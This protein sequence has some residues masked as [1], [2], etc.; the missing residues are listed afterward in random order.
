MLQPVTGLSKLPVS[1]AD[2]CPF[3]YRLALP[4]P[5]SVKVRFYT[6]SVRAESL[7][8]LPSIAV[9]AVV[10]AIFIMFGSSS[11]ESELIYKPLQ[12]VQ[13]DANTHN[14]GWRPLG[15]ARIISSEAWH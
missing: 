3:R 6:E 9:V 4:P 1:F 11:L 13:P 15:E 10:A 7:S 12:P 14:H 2:A 5:L 8:Y